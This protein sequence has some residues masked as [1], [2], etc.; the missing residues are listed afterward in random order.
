MKKAVDKNFI[1]SQIDYYLKKNGWSKYELMNQTSLSSGIIYEWYNGD[2]FPT[3]KNIISVC[4]A[5]GISLSEFFATTKEEQ[6][7]AY[8]DELF[9]LCAAMNDNQRDALLSV[10]KSMVGSGNN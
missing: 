10:A 5:F 9:K 1:L 6:I 4:D 3:L 8:E 7:G 2:T